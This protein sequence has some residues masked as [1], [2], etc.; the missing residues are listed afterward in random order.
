M[1]FRKLGSDEPWLLGMGN[2]EGCL[3]LA[4]P[5]RELAPGH[6]APSADRATRRLVAMLDLDYEAMPIKWISPMHHA[7]M[8]ERGKL[9]AAVSEYTPVAVKASD[10]YEDFRISAVAT[11]PPCSL[12]ALAAKEGFWSLPATYLREV[13]DRLGVDYA[14]TSL[15]SLLEALIRFA[16]PAA[17]DSEVVKYMQKRGYWCE[18]EISHVE[19]LVGFDWMLEMFDAHF[20]D[21]L[22]EEIKTA[23]GAKAA[24]EDYIEDVMK[25][26]AFG[27]AEHWGWGLWSA[28]S[29]FVDLHAASFV[30]CSSCLLF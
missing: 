30:M 3:A 19:D 6:F 13:S 20:A 23:R 9:A 26:K 10:E 1:M 21:T 7:Y 29:L 27:L 11:G 4:W 15:V 16:I 28:S 25:Y 12:L 18:G 14:D 17:T 24:Y 2:V 22:R 5:S 8:V